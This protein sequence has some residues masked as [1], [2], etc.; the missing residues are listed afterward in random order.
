M[1]ST[2]ILSILSIFFIAS[3]DVVQAVEVED[4]RSLKMI[5]RTSSTKHNKGKPF[6]FDGGNGIS[7]EC[8]PLPSNH[9]PKHPHHPHPHPHKS[10]TKV[11]TSTIRHSSTSTVTG[12]TTISD[13]PTST[14]TRSTVTRSTGT[15]TSTSSTDS[16]STITSAITSATQS[17]DDPNTTS[18]KPNGDPS[19]T[20]T[21]SNSDSTASFPLISSKTT[22]IT[23]T[24]T[25]AT[26][27][28][29]SPT[30]SP[31]T[32]VC[33]QDYNEVKQ[34]DSLILNKSSLIDLSGLTIDLN[35]LNFGK[36]GKQESQKTV[37]ASA[38]DDTTCSSSTC[39]VKPIPGTCPKG[40]KTAKRGEVM[41]VENKGG[42]LDLSELSIDLNILS[43]GGKDKKAKNGQRCEADQCCYQ[44]YS[45]DLIKANGID[46]DLCI[47]SGT[48]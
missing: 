30:T 25:T 18:T 20:F 45:N 15:P 40:Y 9:H 47:L 23:P 5:R 19:T 33:P 11:V 48:C 31:T 35:I 27:S 10:S 41:T 32:T 3:Y 14:V 36:D 46:I 6:I 37:S 39:C 13:D 17:N 21:Q 16:T 44:A 2:F 7:Y 24:T 12:K 4:L 38:S 26:T 28:T 34:G 22:T 42:L 43:F 29:T 8:T 1:K